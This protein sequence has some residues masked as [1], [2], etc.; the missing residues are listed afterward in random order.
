MVTICEICVFMWF[1]R[2]LE[3]RRQGVGPQKDDEELE[4]ELEQ[5]FKG[6][7]TCCYSDVHP[8]H[9]WALAEQERRLF[10]KNI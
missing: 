2:H 4:G 8:N 5:G 1:D 9:P 10:G 7:F 6:G 3:S